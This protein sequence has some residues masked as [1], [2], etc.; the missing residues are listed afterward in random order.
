MQLTA[1]GQKVIIV[2]NRGPV[3]YGVDACGARVRQRGEGGLV[4]VLRFLQDDDGIVWVVSAITPEDRAVS[5]EGQEDPTVRYRLLRHD[6]SE[7]ALFYEVSSS[8]MLWF[9]Q[10]ELGATDINRADLLDAWRR[11]YEPANRR[12]AEAVGAE[13]AREPEAVVMFNDYHLY[14]A[15]RMV[16]DYRPS[17]TLVHYIHIPWPDEETWKSV[18]AEICRALHDGLL[19]NDVIGFQSRRWL[20]RFVTTA[21][22]SVGAGRR[23][24]VLEYRGRATEC[25]VRP[26]HVDSVEL[27]ALARTAAVRSRRAELR[28]KHPAKLL[29]R[30]ERSDPSKGTEQGLRAYASYLREHPDARERTSMLVL[31]L[32]SRQDI[33]EFRTCLERLRAT[34]RE[35]N[36]E[37]ATD[38]WTPLD[39]RVGDD[40]ARSVAA[41]VE[42]DILVV[43]PVL[44]GLNLVAKEGPL[45][46][47]RDGVL[48]LSDGAG[49]VEELRDWAIVVPSGD[50]G[51]LAEAIARAD[52]MPPSERRVRAD[53]LRRHVG[54]GDPEAWLEELLCRAIEQR[55]RGAGGGGDAS[56]SHP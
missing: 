35:L 31:V 39:L 27:T 21:Q 16:R 55:R 49:A 25:V 8:R 26:V 6:P 14:L 41:Y 40:F 10:H 56:A 24:D 12:F 1:A 11:G 3:S 37:F 28:E 47:E 45:L 5:L 46:S 34:A 4:S 20:E 18:P 54:R 23:G 53:G 50:I 7:Y 15:P 13:L 22:N 52:E 19:A 48:I 42:Y 32:P 36:E 30:V 9:A 38:T 44:D 29:L 2:S 33:A 51:L 17:T 43:S